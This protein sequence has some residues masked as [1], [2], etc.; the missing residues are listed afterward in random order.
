M[1]M[2]LSLI[3]TVFV[4]LNVVQSNLAGCKIIGIEWDGYHWSGSSDDEL[5]FITIQLVWPL[6]M[7]MNT[8]GFTH[9]RHDTWSVDCDSMPKPNINY[10]K[11]LLI[12]VFFVHLIVYPILRYI[13]PLR[14]MFRW[15]RSANLIRTPASRLPYVCIWC[16]VTVSASLSVYCMHTRRVRP[17]TC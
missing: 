4:K 1:C 13:A 6:W 12:P 5:K 7:V 11:F 9:N 16:H 17:M 14:I 2:W 3:D 15:C 10:P 8:T